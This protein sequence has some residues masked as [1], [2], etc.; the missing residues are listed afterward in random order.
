MAPRKK[1]FYIY[2]TRLE[3]FSSARLK[4]KKPRGRK[5][6]WPHASPA[7][8]AVARSGFYFTPEPSPEGVDSV[9]CHM[10][11]CTLNGW[12][13]EDI[14]DQAHFE[15]SPNCPIAILRQKPWASLDSSGNLLSVDTDHN[16]HGESAVLVRLQTYFQP[17]NDSQIADAISAGTLV[18]SF[19]QLLLTATS[20][21][22]HDKKKGWRPTSV[23]MALAGFY[24]SPEV[25]TKDDS[26]YCP[27]CELSLDEWERT[28]DP[29]AEHKRRRPEC[30][31][32]TSRS[33]LAEI[34]IM[35]YSDIMTEEVLRSPLKTR[36]KSV[37]NSDTSTS[38][39]SEE[40]E[41]I[42]NGNSTS[43]K[44][45]G[46]K[47]SS[48]K[49]SSEHL[50]NENEEDHPKKKKIPVLKK[51]KITTSSEKPRVS[52]VPTFTPI[53]AK[54]AA[55]AKAKAK[56][57]STST[58]KFR[59]SNMDL[60]DDDDLLKP[61]PNDNEPAAD[62]LAA[63]VSPFKNYARA[64]AAN[65]KF[66]SNATSTYDSMASSSGVRVTHAGSVSEKISRFE[67]LL[68]S[69]PGNAPMA[70]PRS[71][72]LSRDM[73][74]SRFSP[75]PSPRRPSGLSRSFIKQEVSSP[76]SA[77]ELALNRSQSLK[78]QYAKASNA[79][80]A[81]FGRSLT[82]HGSVNSSPTNAQKDPFSFSVNRLNESL[83]SQHHITSVDEVPEP[84]ETTPVPE[85]HDALK[86]QLVLEPFSPLFAIDDV[87]KEKEVKEAPGSS[88]RQEVLPDIPTQSYTKKTSEIFLP[89][90]DFK[91]ISDSTNKRPTLSPSE[92][93]HD[94]AS[95]NERNAFHNKDID[96]DMHSDNDVENDMP[97][98]LPPPIGN[99]GGSENW[100][101]LSDASSV[102]S[103]DG[104][105][106]IGST[107]SNS[108]QALR[109]SSTSQRNADSPNSSI[110]SIPSKKQHASAPFS[111][112]TQ[113][114]TIEAKQ[115][116]EKTLQSFTQNKSPRD[117]RRLGNSSLTTK[118][119]SPIRQIRT[120]QASSRLNGSPMKI[121]LEAK[122][123]SKPK[124]TEDPI[125][126]DNNETCIIENIRDQV[127]VDN[128]DGNEAD[129]EGCGLKVRNIL[130]PA[131][132]FN[133]SGTNVKSPSSNITEGETTPVSSKGS[134]LLSGISHTPERQTFLSRS[135]FGTAARYSAAKAAARANSPRSVAPK[136]GPL[137]ESPSASIRK[138]HFGKHP[139]FPM[140]TDEG[141]PSSEKL[142]TSSIW[143]PIDEDSVFDV[144]ATFEHDSDV[145]LGRL[146]KD[147]KSTDGKE[148]LYKWLVKHD[149]MDK[150]VKEFYQFLGQLGEEKMHE[151]FDA[152]FSKLEDEMHRALTV[153]ESLP[154]ID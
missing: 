3:T 83:S 31:F 122:P 112:P 73:L 97:L 147:G 10:C 23:R 127:D 115:N 55:S 18:K 85:S 118:F 80:S 29:I 154:T 13:P 44:K 43:G 36:S 74:S 130:S 121:K 66:S 86:N 2:E 144:M 72:K 59:L 150:T 141:T 113:T 33:K 76:Q 30:Y 151:R 6:T 111:K 139:H 61:L 142:N 79:T 82:V 16:P 40:Q 98:P 32:F 38:Q 69:S 7:A 68:P 4:G 81:L 123:V 104:R 47:S 70:A 101:R 153:L 84:K 94:S 17:L 67:E 52:S 143:S 125:Q 71:P 95:D 58:K 92:I 119:G 145:M 117:G 77:F 75:K 129:D 102:L 34:E 135:P 11:G 51:E 137:T 9:T 12:E 133:R 15:C 49:R 91:E 63:T 39:E 126:T 65:R 99:T 25:S 132:K 148:Q 42:D 108:N 64:N 26:S 22:P 5:V 1:T 138:A 53:T 124:A 21:W 110:H 14:P 20:L 100:S 41:S 8:T 136:R 109:P 105:A 103:S 60:S 27:Y 78:E 114:E 93:Y 48:K 62:F 35:K 88:L 28:N 152:L 56:A 107:N 50:N 45:A 140:P 54:G 149:L 90:G 57:A 146:L 120:G 46:K 37:N 89:K 128:D 19:S 131:R 134:S 87:L 96:Q 106:S 24:Y 116:T